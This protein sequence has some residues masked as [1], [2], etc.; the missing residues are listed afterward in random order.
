M[1]GKY[2][3]LTVLFGLVCLFP[4][5]SIA[6]AVAKPGWPSH[7]RMLSGPNGGQWFALGD[8]IAE[9]LSKNVAPTTNRMGG[10]MANIASL[11]KGAGDMGFSLTCF[12]GASMSGEEEYR[13]IQFDNATLMVNV[14]PQVM[15]FL[16]RKDVAERHGIT[17]V[18]SFLKAKRPLRFASLKPGT[19][20]EFV[21][22]L[23]LKYGY[24]TSFDELRERGW[25]I[26]FNNYAETADNLVS[27]D[28]D[29]FAY[30][31][32]IEAPLILTMEQHI[33]VV[34]LP[35]EQRVLDILAEKFKTSTHVIE[36]GYYKG[37]KSPI[38]TLSDWTCILV[39]KD[40]PKDLVFAA[41]KALW[42]E[43]NNISSVTSDFKRLSP[44][45]ALPKGLEAHPGSVEFW[46][47]LSN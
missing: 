16:L 42:E 3:L 34:I 11:N 15:Y 12:L 1:L 28:L 44:Q 30:T 33:D 46:K 7:L 5:T 26:S 6:A 10:G 19:A 18:E 45:T 36:P 32:S 43:V 40:L 2:F 39:R 41:N 29:C 38:L 35:M 27:G 17:D 24:D 22:R 25:T 23:L 20:S 14:Y 31:A 4:Q 47:T 8:P 21:L 37:V 9:A 13:D